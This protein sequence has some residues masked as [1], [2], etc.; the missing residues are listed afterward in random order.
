MATPWV[1]EAYYLNRQ[2]ELRASKQRP[3]VDRALRRGKTCGKPYG[4]DFVDRHGMDFYTVA[5]EFDYLKER[6][7]PHR[8]TVTPR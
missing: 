8:Q 3:V 1:A 5:C 2:I 7:R 6:P 4:D